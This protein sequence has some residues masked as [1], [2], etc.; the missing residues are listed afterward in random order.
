MRSTMSSLVA[1]SLAAQGRSTP[2]EAMAQAHTYRSQLEEPLA[3]SA[4]SA[5]TDSARAVNP[6]R[7]A[8]AA[9]GPYTAPQSAYA[10]ESSWWPTT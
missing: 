3:A 9:L 5:T 8:R 10:G 7:P 6:E 1:S 4:D 2:P